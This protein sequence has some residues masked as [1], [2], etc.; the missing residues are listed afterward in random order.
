MGNTGLRHTFKLAIRCRSAFYSIIQHSRR[1]DDCN[2]PIFCFCAFGSHHLA[3]VRRKNI[4]FYT[5]FVKAVKFAS[6]VRNFALAAQSAG[7]TPEYIR[8][9]VPD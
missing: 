3:I 1:N 8:G 5:F 7:K 4:H 9:H 6:T 2:F